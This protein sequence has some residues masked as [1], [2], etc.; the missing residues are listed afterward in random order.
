MQQRYPDMSKL[1]DEKQLRDLLKLAKEKQG[2][3]SD[4][5]P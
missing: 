4:S 2:K 5:A 1:E 3:P